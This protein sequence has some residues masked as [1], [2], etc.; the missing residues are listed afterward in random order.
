MF[1]KVNERTYDYDKFDKVLV[2]T[3]T[4]YLTNYKFVSKI[5]F[6]GHISD[7]TCQKFL[8]VHINVSKTLKENVFTF[9]AFT[10]YSVERLASVISGSLLHRLKN[11]IEF[12]EKH[13]NTYRIELT[14]ATINHWLSYIKNDLEPLIHLDKLEV[15]H[16]GTFKLFVKKFLNE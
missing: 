3:E 2:S 6:Y 5:E 11:E 1:I 4:H 10:P 8:E 9:D 7:D 15:I 12:T 16:E 13:T 14:D